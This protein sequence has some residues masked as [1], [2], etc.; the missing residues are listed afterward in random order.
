MAAFIV[1]FTDFGASLW[2]PTV[3]IERFEAV[4][5]LFVAVGGLSC[6]A[7]ALMCKTRRRHKEDAGGGG[8]APRDDVVARVWR[9]RRWW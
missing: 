4:A 7:A 1:V 5:F 8:I 2:S 6:E 3:A 9:M